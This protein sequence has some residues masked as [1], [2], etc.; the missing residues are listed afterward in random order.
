M[1]ASGARE[2]K[3][4][5]RSERK[6][7]HATPTSHR[8][9]GA[10]V[11]YLIEHKIT[12]KKYVGQ[13]RYF[14]RRMKQHLRLDSSCRLMR[15]AIQQDGIQN[16][17]TKV[18]AYCDASNADRVEA[19]YIRTH[20]AVTPGGYNISAG[21]F[22]FVD[23]DKGVTALTLKVNFDEMQA[24]IDILN[25]IRE[26]RDFSDSSEEETCLQIKKQLLAYHPDTS[27][28]PDPEK[29]DQLYAKLKEMRKG[30]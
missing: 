18:L 22:R 28:N 11:I 30:A 20:N 9:S 27:A 16:F 15:D 4:T 26:I 14:A 7:N 29:C 10:V 13:T 3:H 23:E 21:N 17:E 25:H 19:F 1:N 2:E 8:P 6:T 5:R 12:K 24:R